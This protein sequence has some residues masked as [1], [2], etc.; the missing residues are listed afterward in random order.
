M[1]RLPTSDQIPDVQCCPHGCLGHV[2]VELGRRPSVISGQAFLP[3]RVAPASLS[4]PAQKSRLGGGFPDSILPKFKS[5]LCN[6]GE[7][8][9]VDR[10]TGFYTYM[11]RTIVS[12][13]LMIVVPLSSRPMLTCLMAPWGSSPSGVVSIILGRLCT[14]QCRSNWRV[15][16]VLER[17]RLDH[18]ETTLYSMALLMWSCTGWR[19]KT[20]ALPKLSMWPTISA[21]K[22]HIGAVL[23]RVCCQRAYRY[24]VF[25]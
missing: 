13:T 19:G 4:A 18:S 6:W 20:V 14:Q 25:T 23:I 10:R 21:W 24:S 17:R 15:R 16:I 5:V 9:G 22:L 2:D 1:S 12:R 7:S 11:W 8:L 3:R